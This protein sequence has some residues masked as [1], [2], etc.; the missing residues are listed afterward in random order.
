MA[1][2]IFLFPVAP[3]PLKWETAWGFGLK[4]PLSKY[5]SVAIIGR[6]CT[7]E[8][9]ELKPQQYF[10]MKIV[11]ILFFNGKEFIRKWTLFISGSQD[12]YSLYKLPFFYHSANKLKLG[13]QNPLYDG[14]GLRTT[15]PIPFWRGTDDIVFRSI[16]YGFCSLNSHAKHEWKLSASFRA[17]GL[18]W[19]KTSGWRLQDL[20]LMPAINFLG[21]LFIS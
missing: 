10:S 9:L 14:D 15:V 7:K 11:F 18:F 4:A 2:H 5:S 12:W 21:T 17:S 3:F 20:S 13:L 19:L 1:L 16:K 6:N 8:T